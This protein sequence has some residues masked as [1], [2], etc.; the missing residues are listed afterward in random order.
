LSGDPV[1]DQADAVL[2]V[3]D[4]A[5]PSRTLRAAYLYGSA[6]AGGLRPESDLDVLGVVARR[7]TAE[8]RRAVINGLLPISGRRTRP[9]EWRP[10][11]LTLVVEDEVRPWRY[12]PR[13]DLQYGEWLR[14]DLLSGR[15]DVWPAPNPDV[16]ILITMVLAAGQSLLGPPA[17][18]L[19]DPVPRADLAR[20]VLDDLERLLED[21]EDDTRNVLL[22]LARMW[23]TLATGDIRTKD[24]AAGWALPLL[25]QRHRR[26]LTLARDAYIGTADDSWDA[27]LPAARALA[28]VMAARV[29]ALPPTDASV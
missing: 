5:L 7:L 17:D 24:A 28:D 8:E 20:A 1:R 4:T 25:S 10:V 21:L 15:V 14:D 9:A 23:S 6:V 22:T 16:A 13:F 26:T 29:R 2:R 27:L 12:P 18:A 19:L 11:E 3:I